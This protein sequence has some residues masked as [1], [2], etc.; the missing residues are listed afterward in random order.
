MFPRA[1]GEAL[2]LPLTGEAAFLL[3]SFMFGFPAVSR[4]RWFLA[5]T[6]VYFSVG[7]S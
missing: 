3:P 2:V 6:F 4:L 7:S 5:F 1:G